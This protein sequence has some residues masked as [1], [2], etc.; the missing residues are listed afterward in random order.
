MARR[1]CTVLVAS[2]FLLT[3]ACGTTD[4]K[5]DEKKTNTDDKETTTTEGDDD[6]T[7]TTEG[8]GEDG[9]ETTT[10]EDGGGG[11]GENADFCEASRSLDTLFDGLEESDYQGMV[12]AVDDAEDEFEAYHDSLPDD[13]QDEAELLIE[14][15]RSLAEEVDKVKDDADVETKVQA[16]F[17]ALDTPELNEA[18]EAID[19]YEEET[20]G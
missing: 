11:N 5:A 13:L 8:D 18:T 2:L 20:C 10:T 1:L 12:D 17:E 14:S 9:D 4:D 6:S 19:A 3:A 15:V 16:A 7:T